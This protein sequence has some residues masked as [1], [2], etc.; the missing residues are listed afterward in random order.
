MNR[1]KRLTASFVKSVQA[2][3]R[4]G[5]GH[6]AFG[7]SLMVRRMRNRRWSK[8]WNQ[9]VVLDGKVTSL[10]LGA[11]PLVTLQEAREHALLNA[12]EIRQGRR[13][14]Y[15]TTRRSISRQRTS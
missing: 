11:Y 9:R 13:L 4:Y 12:R 14:G 10:G 5:D 8:N 15:L 1:P 2:P 7:L 3:G 6:G